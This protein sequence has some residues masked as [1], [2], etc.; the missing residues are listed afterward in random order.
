MAMNFDKFRNYGLIDIHDNY[1]DYWCS[2]LIGG[3]KIGVYI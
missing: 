1:V 2:E 3:Q